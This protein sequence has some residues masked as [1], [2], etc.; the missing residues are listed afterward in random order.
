MDLK[1]KVVLVTG[2]AVGIGEAICRRFH[3][4]GAIVGI[5][6]VDIG[7][8]TALADGL[9]GDDENR[10]MVVHLDVARAQDWSLAIETITSAHGGIDVLVNNAGIYQNTPLEGIGEADWDR[11]MEVNAKGPFL[12]ARSVMASM[13]SR[14][15]GSIVNMSSVAGIKGSAASHYASSKGAVGMLTKSIALL[16]AKDGIRCNSVHPG[17]VET[18]MGY[19]AVPESERSE[20]LSKVPL[21]RYAT[22]SEIANVVVF[23]ASSQASF[24]TGTEIVV[25]GGAL[26]A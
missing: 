3:S 12:G 4:E 9:N 25:D 8:A 2:G 18:A 20:R 22:P 15:G 7:A 5:A 11:M 14:G 23:L 19:A 21:G 6:D 16:G 24:M 1:N 17:L 26:I 10:A 13:R